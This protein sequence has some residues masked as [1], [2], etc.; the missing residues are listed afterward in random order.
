MSDTFWTA[1]FAG[2]PA[3][4]AAVTTLV[5]AIKTQKQVEKV[6]K[7]TNSLTDRLVQTTRTEAHAAG[8]KEE[9]DRQRSKTERPKE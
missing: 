5:V 1:F 3:A 6:E 7:A 9:R 8:A 4:I 2:L